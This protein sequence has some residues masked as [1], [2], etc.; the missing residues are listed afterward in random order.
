MA[1]WIVLTFLTSIAAVLVSVPFIRKLDER[2]G[3]LFGVVVYRD[4]IL[5][6]ERDLATGLI[7]PSQASS[8]THE[9]KLRMLAA[10]RAPEEARSSRSVSPNF[11][12]VAVTGFVV[13]G[14]V[15]LYAI[16]G[17]PDLPSAIPAA[18]ALP[19]AVAAPSPDVQNSEVKS[20]SSASTGLATVDEMISRLASRLASKP[21]DPEGWRMLGWSYFHTDR[22]PDAAEAYAKA[23]SLRPSVAAFQSSYGE[24][25]FRASNET[26]TPEARAAFDK[27]LKLDPKE[28]RA[29]FFIGLSQ[30]QAGNKS[31]ALEAWIALLK[32]AAPGDEWVPDLKTRLSNLAKETGTALDP[33]LSSELPVAVSVPDVRPAV[34]GSTASDIAAAQT[35]T[36]EDRSAMIRRMVDGLA[37]RLAQSPQDSNGWIRLM[38]ARKVLGELDAAKDSVKQALLAFPEAGQDRDA[39]VR[40]AR[41]LG[42]LQ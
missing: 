8:A 22:Y 20:P 9:I 27:A 6:V 15:I 40:E 28:P 30:E 19:Q 25:L 2:R 5:E 31:A 36:E 33:N 23:A 37:N 39:I 14:S 11:A 17:R 21:D 12:I 7:D 34:P 3:R 41:E 1:L 18:R 10:D 16:Q 42:L 32:D 24:A 38:K 29:R 26:V 4:Q 35:M 13:L